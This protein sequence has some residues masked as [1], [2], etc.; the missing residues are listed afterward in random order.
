MPKFY[1]MQQNIHVGITR[2]TWK[3]R[4]KHVVNR[5]KKST[6]FWQDHQFTSYRNTIERG[7]VNK[8]INEKYQNFKCSATVY[9][10][11]L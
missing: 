6:I 8:I 1:Y 10:I 4:Q 9:A 11:L 7:K 5:V 2:G 3:S